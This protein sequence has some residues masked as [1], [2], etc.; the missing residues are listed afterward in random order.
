[1][2]WRFAVTMASIDFLYIRDDS[3]SLEFSSS[4]AGQWLAPDTLGG[5]PA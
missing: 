4:F 3:R 2:L 1:M 5:M